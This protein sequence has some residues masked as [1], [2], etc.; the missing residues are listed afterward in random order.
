MAGQ[1]ILE[2]FTNFKLEPWARRMISRCIAIVPAIFAVAHYG[3]HGIDTLMI[4]SQVVLSIQL[5]FAVIPLIQ[6]TSDKYKMGEFVNGRLTK[7]IGWTMAAIIAVLNGY[8]V[9]SVIFPKLQG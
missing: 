8:L 6:F 9:L 7:T 3:T 2:G 5:S 1:V 4:G